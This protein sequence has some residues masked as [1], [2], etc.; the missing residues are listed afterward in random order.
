MQLNII[1]YLPIGVQ[2][3][4]LEMMESMPDCSRSYGRTP[5]YVKQQLADGA[6][7]GLTMTD[8]HEPFHKNVSARF[9]YYWLLVKWTK[10]PLSFCQTDAVSW[11]T[12]YVLTKKGKGWVWYHG[13]HSHCMT[14][15]TRRRTG[16]SQQQPKWKPT[17]LVPCGAYY[18]MTKTWS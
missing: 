7:I 8:T 9:L 4:L 13:M 12:K 5:V 3:I 16:Y 10:L 1:L 15:T 11:L 6:E 18:I 14:L 2:K 17:L